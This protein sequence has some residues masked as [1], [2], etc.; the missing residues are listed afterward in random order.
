MERDYLEE[1]NNALDELYDCP[2]L[3]DQKRDYL[4]NKMQDIAESA[5]AEAVRDE[6][7]KD[8]LAEYNKIENKKIKIGGVMFLSGVVASVGSQILYG[9]G[10]NPDLMQNIHSIAQ[11]VA[12]ISG[13]V[14]LAVA[15]VGFACKMTANYIKKDLN[16]LKIQIGKIA[17]MPYNN[18]MKSIDEDNQKE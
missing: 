14:T 10:V 12:T 11:N 6:R 8:A 5:V 1:Y 4:Y 17:R 13:S 7:L 16:E 18:L 2:S 9:Y 15:T 3:T